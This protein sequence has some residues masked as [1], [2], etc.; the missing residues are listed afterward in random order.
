MVI[1]EVVASWVGATFNVSM[2][3][4]R[5]LNRPLIR[6]K[7]PN[8]F[9]T[10]T[11]SVCLIKAAYLYGKTRRHATALLY[12]PAIMDMIYD[13]NHYDWDD[14]FRECY[15]K[16]VAVYRDGNRQPA[17]FFN[18]AETAFLA[19]IGCTPQE[20]YDF[21][22]DWCGAQEP[23]FATVL[24]IT[25]VR[26]D[27]FLTIQKGQ[28]TG[29]V[30]AVSD[31]PAKDAAVA[32]FLWLPRQI[33]KARAKLAGEMPAE[34]MYGCGGDRT[35]FKRVKVHPADFLRV[36]WAARDDDQKIIAYVQHCIGNG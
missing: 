16:A 1:R 32:G 19:S 13:V 36:V 7:T 3:N 12:Q 15:V 10:K 30:I 29:H 22:E 4:P 9:S 23:S 34:L 31:L 20:L 5:P 18:A 6:V 35:F 25:A 14:L 2:L 33:A 17:T 8:L 28:P 24:L 11:E 21:A 27:Y 26:R